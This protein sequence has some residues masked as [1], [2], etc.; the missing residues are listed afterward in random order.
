MKNYTIS[1]TNFKNLKIINFSKY[2][3]SRGHYS[4][5]FFSPLLNE[6]L[7]TNISEISEIFAK[8]KSMRGFHIQLTNP[9]AKFIRVIKGSIIDY[10]L[11]LR[12]S[13]STFSKIFQYRLTGASNDLIYLPAG[14]AHGFFA[15]ED[16]FIIYTSSSPY[17]P[18]SDFGVNFRDPILNYQIPDFDPDLVS[19]KDKNFPTLA[20]FLKDI[21]EEL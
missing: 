15:E 14:F 19:N 9:Q 2:E 21:H 1:E 7:N 5:F 20:N 8:A 12:K 18:K 13:S 6:Y 3:D 10:A 4:K 16:S 17:D 11:D